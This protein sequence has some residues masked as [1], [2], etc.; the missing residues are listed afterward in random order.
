MPLV[1][2]CDGVI[3][4]T[5]IETSSALPWFVGDSFIA[6]GLT[7]DF[8]IT[9]TSFTSSSVSSVEGETFFTSTIISFWRALAGDGSF[10][11]DVSVDSFSTVISTFLS[12]SGDCAAPLTFKSSSSSIRSTELLFDSTFT[13]DG[14]R[15]TFTTSIWDDLVVDLLGLG[16]IFSTLNPLWAVVTGVV[17]AAFPT[18]L[19]GLSPFPVPLSRSASSSQS[20]SSFTTFETLIFIGSSAVCCFSSF[21]SVTFWTTKTP[22]DFSL[23]FSSTPAAFCSCSTPTLTTKEVFSVEDGVVLVFALVACFVGVSVVPVGSGVG[24]EE[25]SF[26]TTM[27]TDSVVLAVAAVVWASVSDFILRDVL[28]VDEGEVPIR[29]I[30]KTTSCFLALSLSS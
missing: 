10:A 24:V 30:S 14:T 1:G 21:T 29:G 13:L 20:V 3:F 9:S 26:S 28:M 25:V 27:W 15:S 16:V 18:F 6:V 23:S 19:F 8:I 7:V 2:R 4:S 5:L 11:E 12:L 17:T 22:S